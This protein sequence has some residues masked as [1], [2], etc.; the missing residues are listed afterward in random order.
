M[1]TK[2][3]LNSRFWWRGP[4]AARYGGK[5]VTKF[6]GKCDGSQ[7]L[8]GLPTQ[9]AALT[10]ARK[11]FRFSN[12]RTDKRSRKKK[13]F[14]EKRKKEKRMWEKMHLNEKNSIFLTT[15]S[16]LSSLLPALMY[17]SIFGN[18]SAIIQRLYS[19]TARYH[20]AMQ[21]VREFNKF[22][23]IPNPLKQRLEEYFQVRR[24]NNS[25]SCVN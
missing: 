19:G 7:N 14:W 6:W 2:N 13:D 4:N 23:Q 5:K 10:F 21:R 24:S 22:Y 15:L 3:P 12:E 16:L 25:V 8:K 1:H 9:A 17:A 20:S 11:N 18:V